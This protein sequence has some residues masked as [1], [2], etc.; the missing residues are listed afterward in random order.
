MREPTFPS[1]LPGW[2]LLLTALVTG[3]LGAHVSLVAFAHHATVHPGA[4]VRHIATG[5]GWQAVGILARCAP[6]G[7]FGHLIQPLQQRARPPSLYQRWC[8]QWWRAFS[9]WSVG[10][11]SVFFGMT[12]LA[13]GIAGALTFRFVSARDVP[14]GPRR[15]R[16]AGYATPQQLQ[17]F[18]APRL[19]S[20]TRMLGQG[21]LPLGRTIPER[22]RGVPLW[23]P[24]EY[25]RQ[26]IWVLGVTGAGKTSSVTK[27]WLAADAALDG[28][29]SPVRMSTVA[30]DVKDPDLWEFAAPVA[31]RYER[32]LIR[33]SPMNPDSMGHNFLDYVHSP[34]DAIEMAETIL[35]NDPEYKRKDPFWRALERNMLAMT[36]QMV[37][38]E[39]PERLHSEHLNAKLRN[40]LGVVP[41]PRSL[42][43]I[44]GLSHLH[45]AEFM[46][47]IQRVDGARDVWQDRF[48][49]LFGA[50]Q[51]K[52]TGT[53]LGLQNVLVIFRDPDVIAATSRSDFHPSVVARQPT[54]LII[55]LPRQ[56]GSQRQVLTALFLRQLLGVLAD[57][58]RDREPH[59]LPVPVTLLLDELGVLGLIPK[60]PEY[61]A[62]FRDIGVSFVIATQ[63]RSQL[64]EVYG[65]ENADTLIA[66]LHTRLIF[67]RD[68]RPE[69]AEEI[70]RALGEVQVPEPGT[71]FEHTSS[72]RVR[73]TG[74]RVMYQVRRLLEPNELRS[75]PEFHAIA[76]LPGDV[77]AHILMPPVHHDPVFTHIARPVSLFEAL[78]HDVRMD[79]VLGRLSP[80]PPMP[81]GSAPSASFLPQSSRSNEPD[82]VTAVDPDPGR[83]LPDREQKPLQLSFNSRSDSGEE[84]ARPTQGERSA[85]DFQSGPDHAE[86]LKAN[87]R[88][89]VDSTGTDVAAAGQ[90]AAIPDVVADADIRADGSTGPT[91]TAE[92]G[93]VYASSPGTDAAETDAKLVLADFVS[94]VVHGDLKDERLPPGSPRGWVYADK[95]GEFLVPW[96]FFR[97]WAK[98][99][100][101]LLVEVEEDW[102]TRGHIRGRASV[103]ADGRAVTCLVFAKVASGQLSEELR[104]LIVQHFNCVRPEDVRISSRS[105]KGWGPD[106]VA[107]VA[108]SKEAILR[109]VPDAGSIPVL[110]ERF[111]QIVHGEG[112]HFL[113]HASYQ[114]G[115]MVYGRW[116][117]MSR[118]GPVLLVER[119]AVKSLFAKIGVRDHS[120][121]LS[122]WKA[123]GI[124]YLGRDVRGEF[125]T[126]RTHKEGREFLA[127]RWETLAKVSL[128]FTPRLGVTLYRAGDQ[129]HEAS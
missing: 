93:P 84:Q 128:S 36:I 19:T 35:A 29:Q 24:L 90:V 129:G 79:Q 77:K 57:V 85:D 99:T 56:P 117:A 74:T 95:R 11:G 105:L 121:I 112:V 10:A 52:V 68:L 34:G 86:D 18:R 2:S 107:G 21:A 110:L 80:L 91:G 67:G 59:E 49:A 124:L 9:L 50:R 109:E 102:T 51:D 96:G 17:P 42:A 61:V 7:L 63:D 106:L 27:R 78:R 15:R 3:L 71:Q 48:S 62:T 66:N 28:V 98:R 75:L 45:P 119:R 89:S 118:E 101:R 104:Q 44:L 12:I 108:A 8:G 4:W 69:Q 54:T 127:L 55:G 43:F 113:G 116:R 81:G 30:V 5:E 94:E 20:A 64:V 73:R 1:R 31:M 23:L 53:W 83:F 72:L 114:Q 32:R 22:G 46:P 39:P 82:T 41:P 92:Q 6:A 58:A 37:C 13:M 111:I 38:E 120:S 87:R 65:Q 60:F 70:C 40:V 47:Y 25:R 97:D 100:Q 123:A 26:H 103:T 76:A 33:W 16:T 115:N 14:T 88:R 126:R 125:Y 122:T